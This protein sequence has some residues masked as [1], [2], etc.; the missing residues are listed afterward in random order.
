MI[1]LMGLAMAARAI[2]HDKAATLQTQAMHAVQDFL[3]HLHHQ[4]HSEAVAYDGYILAFYADLLSGLP[5]E[6]QQK[7]A[8]H[9]GIVKAMAASWESAAPGD[10]IN[11]AE[12]G[13]VEPWE[14]T[15]HLSAHIKLLR[16]RGETPSLWHVQRCDPQKLRSDKL[17]VWLDRKAENA[18]AF[19]PKSGAMASLNIAVLR[20][21]WEPDDLAAVISLS[22]SVAGHLHADTGS[23]VLGTA[24]SGSSQTPVI[25]SICPRRNANSHLERDRINAPVIN[26]VD[27]KL[28]GAGRLVVCENMDEA[29]SQ[30]LI[31]MT[32][33]YSVADATLNRVTRQ[34]WLLS[35]RTLVVL[36]T[37]AGMGLCNVSW[38]WHSHADAAWWAQDGIAVLHLDQTLL[39]IASPGVT[40]DASQIT[41]RPGSRG[42]QT[43]GVEL[44]VSTDIQPDVI[45]T[46]HRWWI[47]HVGDAPA[48]W[49][50]HDDANTLEIAGQRLSAASFIA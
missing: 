16:L 47:F 36:D 12:L 29:T 41:R 26:G 42:Q 27:Q 11:V 46:I 19:A 30:A 15:F 21:G 6:D 40:L 49:R 34:C 9:P 5:A 14:M 48:V 20:S 18:D 35:N 4:G 44:P 43:L 45:T 3:D 32:A 33:C 10:A 23:L 39:W 25:S 1:G 7:L 38:S 50:L 31:D 22:R 13:D 37:I 8:S 17:I 2:G 28:K 24:G